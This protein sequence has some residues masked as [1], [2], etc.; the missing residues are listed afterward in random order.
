MA[1]IA[2]DKEFK[3][4]RTKLSKIRDRL[5]KATDKAP[6]GI[7]KELFIGSLNIRNS[8]IRSMVEDPKTGR[9]YRKGGKIHKASAP[10]ESPAVDSGKLI[11]SIFVDRRKT[12]V[13]VGSIGKAP[14][15]FNLEFGVKKKTGGIIQRIFGKPEWRLEPRPFLEP[16]YRANEN[17]IKDRVGKLG[18]QVIENI[19]KGIS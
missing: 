17:E 3:K 12:E 19:M 14:Y 6:D 7:V 2:T 15:S 4:L 1:S 18:Y 10:W 16:A 11:A 5:I 13:E 9:E 8:A